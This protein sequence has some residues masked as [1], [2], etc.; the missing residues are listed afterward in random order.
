MP[1]L[2]EYHGELL[3]IVPN[4]IEY[5]TNQG[6]T[7]HIRCYSNNI[8]G[9]FIDLLQFDNELFAIMSKRG[10][11]TS[12]NDGKTWSL[13]AHSI[14]QY[15][16][17]LTLSSDGSNLIAITSKVGLCVSRDAGRSWRKRQ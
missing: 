15:G 8:D 13:R 11:F 5:S 2:I 9:D 6:L 17:F 12:S 4:G 10:L 14:P 1:Q 3:R 16:E 7:W